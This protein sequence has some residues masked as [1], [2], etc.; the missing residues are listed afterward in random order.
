MYHLRIVKLYS[1]SAELVTT[2][3]AVWLVSYRKSSQVNFRW[4]ALSFAQGF[5][6]YSI[7]K[8]PSCYA[9]NAEIYFQLCRSSKRSSCWQPT[10]QRFNSTSSPVVRSNPTQGWS[11]LVWS[12]AHVACV[13][14]GSGRCKW[15]YYMHGWVCFQLMAHADW[16]LR[17]PEKAYY[18]PGCRTRAIRFFLTC[19]F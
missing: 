4:L 7:M 17:G 15:T 2:C 9:N 6:L 1:E 3:A 12:C 18:P 10:F 5:I 13:S 19:K 14:K 16:L 8:T 11:I